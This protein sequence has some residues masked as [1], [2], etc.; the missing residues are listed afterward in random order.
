MKCY[1]IVNND[2]D[3]ILSIKK[4]NSKFDLDNVSKEDSNF[5]NLALSKNNDFKLNSKSAQ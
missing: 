5:T 4:C 2:I 1:S 3:W